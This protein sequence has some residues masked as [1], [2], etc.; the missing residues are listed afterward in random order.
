MKL[1][2]LAPVVALGTTL[3]VPGCGG[4]KASVLPTDVDL[5][6]EVAAVSPPPRTLRV[7]GKPSIWVRFAQ[8]MDASTI[9]LQNV[10]LKID[11]RRLPITLVWAPESLTLHIEY[12]P[13]LELGRTYTIELRPGVRTAA[14]GGLAR[15]FESQFTVLSVRVPAD[16]IPARNTPDE[17]P[18][19]TLGWLATERSA[20]PVSYEIYAGDDS[21][22]VATRAVAPLARVRTP[23]HFPAQ[24]WGLGRRVHWSIRAVND[25][26]GEWADGPVWTFE[27]LP[28]GTAIDSLEVG[29]DEYGYIR[30][31]RVFC[32][33][34]VISAGPNV[35]SAARWRLRELGA[36]LK[37]ARVR[38]D[39]TATFTNP[40]GIALYTIVTPWSACAIR[41]PGPPYTDEIDGRLAGSIPIS[42]RGLRVESSRLTAHA[43]AMIRGF[44][45]DGYI[46]RGGGDVTFQVQGREGVV[47]RVWYY[48]PTSWAAR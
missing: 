36:P 32:N 40:S 7:I 43:E 23:Y 29:I 42:D 2:T 45:V 44:P 46:I 10:S 11:T 27:T 34:G 14:G 5:P 26:T 13:P 33:L 19:V 48:R 37:L 47:Y 8:P 24:S 1:A 35:P 30:F 3:L 9:N 12:D 21:S 15:V 16:P 17:S 22:A 41:N 38:L 20:G 4:R 28:A 6:V 31:E 18:H 39:L 25:S